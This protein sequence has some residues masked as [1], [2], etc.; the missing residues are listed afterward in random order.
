MRI[1]STIA[2]GILL[3]GHDRPIGPKTVGIRNQNALA[4][5]AL[6]CCT[7]ASII[8][9]LINIHNGSSHPQF[10]SIPRRAAKVVWILWLVA[11][12]RSVLAVIPWRK[13]RRVAGLART[14]PIVCQSEVIAV[15]LDIIDG[16]SSRRCRGRHGGWP[17]HTI[18]AGIAVTGATNRRVIVCHQFA[19]IRFGN[20]HVGDD[21]VDSRA[22]CIGSGIRV[23][24]FVGT[25]VTSAKCRIGGG[26][27][28]G[29]G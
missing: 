2:T 12:W 16:S 8:L 20:I 19:G 23:S 14:I 24:N 4:T 17:H 18:I 29:R 11:S 28:V 3:H 7:T 10:F 26:R 13:S 1:L 21:P 25:R 15:P 22:T 9:A 5:S 27:R 6:R